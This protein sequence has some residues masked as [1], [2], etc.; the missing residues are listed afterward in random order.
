MNKKFSTL[1]AVLLAAGAWTTLEAKVV[2]VAAP[3]IGNAYVIGTSV[4]EVSD[5][6]TSLLNADG[7]ITAEATEV[8]ATTTKWTLEGIPET[9]FFYLK[10]SEEKYLSIAS[11]AGENDFSCHGIIPRWPGKRSGPFHNFSAKARSGGQ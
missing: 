8:T 2:E 7:T 5:E 3:Q 1:V 11:E 6:I 10:N 4:D 9:D